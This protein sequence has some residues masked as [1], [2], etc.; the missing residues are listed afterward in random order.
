MTEPIRTRTDLESGRPKAKAND[1]V[2]STGSSQKKNTMFTNKMDEATSKNDKKYI[3]GGISPLISEIHQNDTTASTFLNS[4]ADTKSCVAS[5]LTKSQKI[6]RADRTKN[7][8]T[9]LN[10]GKRTEN[11]LAILTATATMDQRVTRSSSYCGHRSKK[12][13]E[14]VDEERT[15]R[16]NKSTH[17]AETTNIFDDRE[18]DKLRR[19]ITAIATVSFDED[20]GPELRQVTPMMDFSERLSQGNLHTRGL[21]LNNLGGTSGNSAK[22][23]ESGLR[24]KRKVLVTPEKE[25]LASIEADILYNYKPPWV[26]SNRLRRHFTELTEQFLTPLNRYFSALIPPISSDFITILSSHNHNVLYFEVT[27]PLIKPWK[28]SNFFESLSEH[29]LP[30]GLIG[31]P[32]AVKSA[33]AAA[34]AFAAAIFSKATAPKQTSTSNLGSAVLD[35]GDGRLDP[36]SNSGTATDSSLSWSGTRKKHGNGGLFTISDEWISLY[37]KFIS[38]GNFA[39]WL[40]RRT[41]EAQDEIWKRYFTNIANYDFDKYLYFTGH[42]S[43]VHLVDFVLCTTQELQISDGSDQH[44]MM[45]EPLSDVSFRNH[46]QPLA[47]TAKGT[48]LNRESP[49]MFTTRNSTS[50]NVSFEAKY[51]KVSRNRS[52]SSAIHGI[53]K[54]THG[55]MNN[56]PHKPLVSRHNNLLTVPLA[57]PVPTH[58]LM[59]ASSD[60]RSSSA[61]SLYRSN[62]GY[63]PSLNGSDPLIHH[64]ETISSQ[65]AILGSHGMVVGFVTSKST[66]SMHNYKEQHKNSAPPQVNRTSHSFNE[67]NTVFRRGVAKSEASTRGSG[68]PSLDILGS[69]LAHTSRVSSRSPHPSSSN[70]V[71]LEASARNQGNLPFQKRCLRSEKEILLLANFLASILKCRER[72]GN[73]NT[74]SC[75]ELCDATSALK[76]GISA[77]PSRRQHSGD[78]GEA[79]TNFSVDNSTYQHETGKSFNN[80]GTGSKKSCENPSCSLSTFFQSIQQHRLCLADNTKMK[81]SRQLEHI[82]A[83]L[84]SSLSSG[85]HRYYIH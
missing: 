85:F 41:T 72:N 10:V 68:S 23:S 4:Q 47:F 13:H 11:V 38:C 34:S 55:Y 45:S 48:P 6:S 7:V 14:F 84:P 70:L 67:K 61:T 2:R 62:Y 18:L 75:N 28:S 80:L 33:S 71:S 83:F 50:R 60:Q 59:K 74:S 32:T 1:K 16:G 82:C 35:L 9:H 36:R 53:K 79:N 22:T 25:F 81:I 12:K 17:V 77:L 57:S 20:T 64:P 39:T 51:S 24:T 78:S 43:L 44:N 58:P 52:H 73:I 56:E 49:D 3:V 30:V 42:V 66:T 54:P 69:D 27:P 21:K 65:K 15:R 46:E 63:S 31:K 76:D 37:S 26:I 19:W 40:S 29:G 5:D 8:D